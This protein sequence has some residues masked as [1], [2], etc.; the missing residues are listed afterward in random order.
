MREKEER[1]VREGWCS[2]RKVKRDVAKNRQADRESE[3]ESQ[4][5][6]D[7][8]VKMPADMQNS[9]SS[10]GEHVTEKGRTIRSTFR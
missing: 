9:L 6:K 5:T 7:W 3:G 10:G 2:E 8:L 4:R 1:R